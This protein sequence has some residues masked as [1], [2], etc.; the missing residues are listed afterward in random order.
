M[1]GANL[2]LTGVFYWNPQYVEAWDREDYR[3]NQ[4]LAQGRE[5]DN[6]R[7]TVMCMITTETDFRSKFLNIGENLDGTVDIH[8]MPPDQFFVKERDSKQTYFTF[9]G[10]TFKVA[11]LIPVNATHLSYRATRFNDAGDDRY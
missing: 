11:D 1:S 6:S 8:I 3:D 10:F 5:V 7:R 9:E 2:D 4:G